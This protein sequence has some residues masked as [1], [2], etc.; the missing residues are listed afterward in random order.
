MT[1]ASSH[2]VAS[3]HPPAIALFS[4][5]VIVLLAGDLLTKSL[6]FSRVAGE[7]VVV[8][9][10][11]D[12]ATTIPHHDPVVLVPGVL[13]LRLTLNQGAV[14]GIGQGG[15]WVFV[16]FSIVAVLFVLG[17][18]LR[19]SACAV[20]LHV[21]L[22]CLLSGALGNLYDRIIFGSVRDQFLLFP[23]SSLPFGWTWPG[24]NSGLYPWIF[25]LADVC[26]VVG[27][28]FLLVLAW[29]K[30]DLPKDDM[31]HQSEHP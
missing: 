7:P 1:P 15:R 5:V 4:L 22:A 30:E 2:L 13:S 19:S 23:G 8:V 26:L 16:F 28:V 25:N 21:M 18:F 17:I 14:F 11:A 6:S 29:K 9:R 3:G 10:G 24:G 27:I 12:A 20:S 31:A